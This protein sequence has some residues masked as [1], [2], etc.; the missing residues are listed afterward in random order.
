MKNIYD[1]I[2]NKAKGVFTTTTSNTTLPGFMWNDKTPESPP[3]FPDPQD[4]P[5]NSCLKIFLDENERKRVR[6]LFMKRLEKRDGFELVF[7]R[8]HMIGYLLEKDGNRGVGYKDGYITC[9]GISRRTLIRIDNLSFT[10][11][12][13]GHLWINFNRTG[14][15]GITPHAFTF[16][17]SVD[18]VRNGEFLCTHDQCVEGLSEVADRFNSR[19]MGI[20]NEHRKNS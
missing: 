9:F 4:H 20:L 7:D 14:I 8:G 19:W 18:Y 17:F 11:R 5:G 1:F 12:G 2:V 15:S 13:L 3:E 10:N 6:G 16:G